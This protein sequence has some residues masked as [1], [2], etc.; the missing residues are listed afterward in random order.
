VRHVDIDIIIKGGEELSEFYPKNYEKFEEKISDLI[1]EM[2]P[3][4]GGWEISPE[5]TDRHQAE[6]KDREQK[7]Q[8]EFKKTLISILK[9]P[10]LLE[11][12]RAIR[13]ATASSA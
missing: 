5:L 1:S 9:E 13:G 12:I 2:F 4:V 11:K 3:G 10:E 7:R 6:K 8:E